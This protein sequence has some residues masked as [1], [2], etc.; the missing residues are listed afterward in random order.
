[1][2]NKSLTSAELE[3]QLCILLHS[4]FVHENKILKRWHYF[5]LFKIH[6]IKTL[7]QF[8]LYFELL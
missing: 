6:W 2:E 8:T 5:N 1:M 4:T 3:N 7:L